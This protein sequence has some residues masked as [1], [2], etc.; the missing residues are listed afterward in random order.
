MPGSSH[1]LLRSI[2]RAAH[3]QR[4]N[5]TVLLGFA[6][7]AVAM[8][9]P[10][11]RHLAT[12]VV[13]AK[14][15]YDS[16]VNI[17]ILGSRMHYALG[18]SES[19]KSVYDNY[20]CAPTP[21]SIANNENHFG[22]ALLYAPFY[23]ATRDP[24][25]AY[26]LLLLLCIALSGFC[27]FVFVRELTGHALAA[28]L[29]GVAYAFSPYVF[30]ELGRIQLVAAQW[31]PLFALF[32]HRA[33]RSGRLVDLTA[34][35]LTFAMQVG[36]CLYYAVFLGVYGVLVGTWLVVR[37][38]PAA[39]PFA[40]RLGAAALITALPVAFM[41]YPYFKARKD[42]P[43][44]RTEDL[45]ASY[46]GKLEDFLKV[47]PENKTLTFLHNAAPGPLEPIAFPGFTLLALAAVALIVPMIGTFRREDGAN[48]RVHM[49][50]LVL[51]IAGA[52]LAVWLSVV[53]RNLVPG[54]AIVAIGAAVWR[55]RRPA[56]LL[57]PLTFLYAVLLFVMV[58]LF[59]GPSPFAING[60]RIQGPYQY[61]YHHVPG[62]DGI[63]YVSRFII[64]IMLA[65]AVLGGFGA[66]LLLRGRRPVRVAGFVVLLLAML[67]ELRNAP[68]SLAQLP[69]KKNLSP[70]YRWL[71]RHPGPEPIATLPSYTR[72]YSGARNDYLALFHRRRT[73]DGKSSWMPPI[74]YAFIFETRRFPRSTMTRMLQ[75]LGVKYLVLHNDEYQPPARRDQILRW[76][77]NR[78][79]TFVRRFAFGSEY[80]YELLPPSDPSVSLLSTPE[81]PKHLKPLPRSELMPHASI[82]DQYVEKSLDGNQESRWRT[83]RNQIAGESWEVVFPSQHKV[84]ALEFGH[85][86]DA[87]DAPAAF[88]LSV[89]QPNGQ[90]VPVVRRPE[91]RFYYDQVY[92][93]KSFVFRLVLP[94]P[95][96]TFALRMQ[97]LDG[98]AGHEWSINEATVWV[99]D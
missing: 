13:K 26:N 51:A 27:M 93:P 18:M 58:V 6:A 24:L 89:L 94:E 31:I 98:V 39:R 75:T 91:L 16:M 55:A 86:K 73:I 84:A 33:A 97:L 5:A 46:A 70:A 37:S 64:L 95:V 4:I 2:G 92:H 9:W 20:F 99:A 63:R 72:G 54:L 52:A 78:P 41:V 44:T 74:T 17:H 19:L 22:L 81:L 53:L 38:R 85:F 56:R 49:Q 82:F 45:A 43:L 71:A 32:L 14:W 35:G 60:A 47:Y 12:H 25:L 65:L 68:V 3:A 59:L 96:P 83:H 40:L 88:T 48:R 61:L 66:S 15:Y 36:C 21:Y 77:D 67:L 42:F 57:P 29:S 8:T 62:L 11:A 90:Y 80:V 10:L 76:L 79:E 30:F 50:S 7:L 34:L 1:R 23:V 28:V 69:N 87:F